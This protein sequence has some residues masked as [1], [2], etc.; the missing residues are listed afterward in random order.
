M[1]R[2]FQVA[3]KYLVVFI[4]P[5]PNYFGLRVSGKTSLHTKDSKTPPGVFP[6]TETSE[7]WQPL[8]AL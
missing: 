5:T 3:S 6:S 2:L 4:S 1:P 8:K 7:L